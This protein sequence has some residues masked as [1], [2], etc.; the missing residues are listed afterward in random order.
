MKHFY[1]LHSLRVA[2]LGAAVTASALASDPCSAA[3]PVDSLH[4]TRSTTI[5]YSSNDGASTQTAAA[6][7]QRLR[8]AAR[9]VCGERDAHIGAMRNDWQSCY[10]AAL[11]SAVAE[12]NLQRITQL[13]QGVDSWSE[14]SPPQVAGEP[15]HGT[16]TPSS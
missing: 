13:H 12:V 1:L 6:L 15:E 11:D 3:T 5:S 14:S 9:D 8:S 16:G 4:E 10:R 2:A 7:Y